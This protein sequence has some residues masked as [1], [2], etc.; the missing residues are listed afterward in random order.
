MAIKIITTIR[1]M[2]E[3]SENMRNN[4]KRIGFVPTMGYLHEGHASLIR[5]SAN[6]TDVSVVSVFV[7]PTQFGPN[8]DFTRYPRDFE[9]DC[10]I[11]ESAGAQIMFAPTT[12]EMYPTGYSTVIKAGNEAKKFEGE[13]RP[14]HFDGVATVVAKLFNAVKPHCA[15]FG[16]KDYQQT[17]V[18]TRMVKDT[19]MDIELIIAPTDREDS[20]LARS[21]RNVY[22]S[23]QERTI[24]SILYRALTTAF[25]TRTKGELHRSA[26]N[27]VLLSVIST[28]PSINVEYAKSAV[29]ESLEEPDNFAPEDNIVFLLAVRLGT[30]RLIDNMVW[31]A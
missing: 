2:Q 3:F 14:G 25:D 19:N 10:R 16:Q 23:Q 11:A 8:E 26:L 7:N 31:K 9:R 28:E 24:A 12:E 20:G 18:I 27:D 21:S 6:D 22:L 17:L 5:R 4:R 29:A 30:T 15:I 1:E 13:F